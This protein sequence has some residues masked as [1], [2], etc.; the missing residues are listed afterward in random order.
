VD[1]IC[2]K[3]LH[4]YEEKK[5]ECVSQGCHETLRQ[6]ME[7]DEDNESRAQKGPWQNYA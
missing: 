5:Q 2:Q 7:K 3:N 1:Q 6:N 4:G